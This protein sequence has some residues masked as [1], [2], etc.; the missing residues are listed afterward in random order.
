MA[1]PHPYPA[2][3]VVLLVVLHLVQAACGAGLGALL[4]RP[5]PIAPGS[6]VLVLTGAVLLSLVVRQVPP[7]GPMIRAFAGDGASDGEQLLAVL[8]AVVVAG[9]L[10]AAGCAFSRRAATR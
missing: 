10:L 3:T 2:R 6:A 9:A 7:L 1:N 4:A 5:F 8:E